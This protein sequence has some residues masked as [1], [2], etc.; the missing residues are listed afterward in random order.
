M[1]NGPWS[2]GTGLHPRSALIPTLPLLLLWAV[3]EE[4][5]EEAAVPN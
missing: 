3:T 1:G 5:P 2:L 4:G